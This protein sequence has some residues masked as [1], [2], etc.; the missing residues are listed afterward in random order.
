M[1][2]D[3]NPLLNEKVRGLLYRTRCKPYTG[4]L[5]HPGMGKFPAFVNMDG[6]RFISLLN[7][8]APVGMA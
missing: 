1:C 2:F 7:A 4:S 5:D 8:N 3:K 6:R